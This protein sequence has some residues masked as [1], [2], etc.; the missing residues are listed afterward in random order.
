M[1]LKLNNEMA[2]ICVLVRLANCVVLSAPISVVVLRVVISA[3][4]SLDS[5]A[6]VRAETWAVVR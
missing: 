4:D 5:W 6:V 1:A 3:A 2:A